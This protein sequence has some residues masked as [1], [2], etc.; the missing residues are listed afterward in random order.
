MD[1]EAKDVSAAGDPHLALEMAFRKLNRDVM[2]ICA[3]GPDGDAVPQLIA[4]LRHYARTYEEFRQTEAQGGRAAAEPD[5][6]P[7]LDLDAARRE[8]AERLGRLRDG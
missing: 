1:D 3:K 7:V 8:L 2:R 4:S 6:N 5:E